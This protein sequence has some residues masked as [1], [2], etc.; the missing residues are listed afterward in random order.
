MEDNNKKNLSKYWRIFYS[1]KSGI[2]LLI[3]I[4][5][6]SILGTVIPQE[7]PIEFY[8]E[9]YSSAVYDII[10]TFS[11]YKVYSSWWFAG[12]TLLLSLN[13]I[14][15]SIRRFKSVVRLAVKKPDI[16]SE[17]QNISN[18]E[19]IEAEQSDPERIFNEMKF[20][21]VHKKSHGSGTLYYSDSGNIGYLGSWLTHLGILLIIIFFTYGKINGYEAFVHGIPGSLLE[22]EDTGL[23]VGI[24]DF[25]ILFRDDYTVEQYI[26]QI[27]IFEGGISV[28]SGQVSVNHPFRTN[29][30]NIYQNGTGW[31]LNALL[32]KNGEAC[33]SRVMYEGDFFIEDNQKI[34]LQFTKFYPDFDEYSDELRTKSPLLNHP[35]MLY[36][37]F[38]DGYRVA[39]DLAHMG[40]IIEFE[41]YSFYIDEPQMYT[42]LQI[43]RNPGTAGALTGSVLLVAGIYLAMFLNPK[44]LRIYADDNGLGKIYGRS[45]KNNALYQDELNAV[46]DKLGGKINGLY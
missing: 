17:I 45:Y 13:L 33:S 4:G 27:R 5:V 20:K 11:L 32:Y 7:Y 1:M 2:I 30:L 31:A 43:V 12:L 24:E 15:C 39:M 37:L 42:V 35:V 26:S 6:L 18:W 10:E 46:L 36:A 34:A 44:K 19:D 23:H 40:D 16:D 25:D 21:N 22:I 38:Y 3:I 41:E 9:N 29:N 28:D 14:L 8:K